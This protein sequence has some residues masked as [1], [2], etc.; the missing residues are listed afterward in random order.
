MKRRV[1]LKGFT[2]LPLAAGGIDPP[3][4]SFSALYFFPKAVLTA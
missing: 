1:I 2:L 3:T 4:Y